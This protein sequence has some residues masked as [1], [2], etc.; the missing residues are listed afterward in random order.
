MEIPKVQI[1]LTRSS[2]RILR[3]LL[4]PLAWVR[5]LR[6]RAS[7]E[8]KKPVYVNTIDVDPVLYSGDRPLVVSVWATWASIWEVTAPIVEQLK[9]EFAGRCEFSYVEMVNR[10][11]L[12]KYGVDVLP[13]VLVYRN[14]KEVARFIN[15]IQIDEPRKA[16]ASLV[17]PATQTA[18][19][20]R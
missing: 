1:R 2:A 10:S 8:D 11:T 13:A 14:G 5:K 4:A 18:S 15:L 6:K 9:T 19:P 12:Q 20:A 16:I 3:M 7:G 17:G